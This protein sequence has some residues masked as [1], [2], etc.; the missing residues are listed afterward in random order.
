[1]TAKAA[2]WPARIER[3]LVLLI[4]LHSFV[5]GL[6]LLLAPVWSAQFAGWKATG[7]EFF[8]RQ[9]G[10][11]HLILAV[12]YVVEHFRAG[13]VILLVTA[14]TTAFVFLLV[15]A[16]SPEVPWAIPFSGATDGM[17]GLAAFL[18]HRRSRRAVSSSCS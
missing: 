8:L 15:S 3:P 4:A 2:G 10:V 18:V 7:P 1:M 11:F 6:M 5:V 16:I 17:M 13:G 9:A 12:G 14:K